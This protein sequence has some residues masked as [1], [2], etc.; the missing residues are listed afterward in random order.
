MAGT[1]SCRAHLI[2][3]NHC[4]PLRPRRRRLQPRSCAA[5]IGDL[6]ERVDQRM[7]QHLALRQSSRIQQRTHSGRVR[8]APQGFCRDALDCVGRIV[9]QLHGLGDRL[10]ITVQRYRMQRRLPHAC[11]LVGQ[12][13]AHCRARPVGL[14]AGQSPHGVA[15]YV[16]RRAVRQGILERVDRSVCGKGSQSPPAHGRAH[17]VEQSDQRT[18]CG[19]LPIE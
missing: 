8:D 7:R 9:Q 4:S 10:A 19:R 1:Q 2:Q 16:G 3:R 17:V 14:D 12:R 15:P 11:L 13:R 18:R 6:D 5:G